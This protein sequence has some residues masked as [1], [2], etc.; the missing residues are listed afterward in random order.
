MSRLLTAVALVAFSATS[1]VAADASD[2]CGDGTVFDA[3]VNK[4]VVDLSAGVVRD[5]RELK[6]AK[7]STVDGDVIVQTKGKG[8]FGWQPEEGEAVWSDEPS[9]V[10]LDAA[11]DAIQLGYNMGR[12]VTQLHNIISIRETLRDEIKNESEASRNA[13]TDLRDKIEIIDGKVIKQGSKLD[14]GLEN[15]LKEVS[16]TVADLETEVKETVN[17]ISTCADKSQ[18]LS[19]DG[20]CVSPIVKCKA[21]SELKLEVAGGSIQGSLKEPVAGAQEFITCNQEGFGPN[22][23]AIQCL[24]T[25]EYSTDKAK[26]EECSKLDPIRKDELCSVCANGKCLVSRR[27]DLGKDKANPGADCAEIS[28]HYAKM[29]VT[30]NNGIYFL[31]TADNKIYETY[32]DF[33]VKGGGWTMVGTI[34]ETNQQAYNNGNCGNDDKWTSNGNGNVNGPGAAA[35]YNKAVFGT[36][37]GSTEADFKSPGW[38]EAQGKDVMIWHVKNGA[39]IS[40]FKGS[41]EFRYYTEN[42]FLANQKNSWWGIYQSRKTVRSGRRCGSRLVTDMKWDT[43]NAAEFYDQQ[44]PTNTRNS[45]VRNNGRNKIEFSSGTDDGSSIFGLCPGFSYQNGCGNHEHGCMGGA[46]ARSSW[47]ND[48]TAADYS[49]MRCASCAASG[50]SVGGK[51]RRSVVMMFVR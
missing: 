9:S 28:A 30:P 31:K 1:G 36:A 34:H 38:W 15:G 29:K 5:K 32:C 8:R 14:E 45:H 19:G 3:I 37:A 33:S 46:M 26:C 40:S 42:K 21:F 24:S 41:A 39:A 51:F 6:R 16:K 12:D 22:P 11:A 7:I 49:G 13:R 18:V 43:N 10:T 23:S 48:F 25:G 20:K 4:C 44:I 27:Q 47:C 35:W 17:A 50:W 2:L